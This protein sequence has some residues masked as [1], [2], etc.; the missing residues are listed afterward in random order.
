MILKNPFKIVSLSNFRTNLKV[1][2]DLAGK[3]VTFLA[4]K[5]AKKVKKTTKFPKM[6]LISGVI[7]LHKCHFVLGL[8]I[9]VLICGWFLY[10]EFL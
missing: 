1:I 8:G 10:P 6:V 9:L 5:V 7:L 2:Y 4:K 3:I